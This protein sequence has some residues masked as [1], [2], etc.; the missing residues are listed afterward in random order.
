MNVIITFTSCCDHLWKSK[1]M[2]LEK[3]GKLVEFFF[4]YFVA[5]LSIHIYLFDIMCSI[6]DVC[7]LI[8]IV[9]VTL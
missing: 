9:T 8:Y 5:T 3:P 7:W 1:F 4:S 6:M 2:A